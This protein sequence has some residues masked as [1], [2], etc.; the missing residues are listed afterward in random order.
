MEFRRC[1][2]AVLHARRF[3]DPGRP[4]LIFGNSLGTDL[5]IWSA[6][7]PALLDR[8]GI[9]LHDQ[10]G[11]GLSEASSGPH[12]IDG[13]AADL[14]A[15]AD[16]VGAE[17]FGLVG[18]SV[19]GMVA[20]TVAARHPDRVSALVLC[21]TAARIGDAPG[22]EARIRSVNAG[23]VEG[24]AD[25]VME[26][27]FTDG[28]RLANPVALRG[29]RTMLPL[30]P[31]GGYAATCMAIRDADLRR[32]AAGIRAPTLCIAGDQDLSTPPDLVREAADLVP[33]AAFVTIAGAG[34]IPC[35]EQPAAFARLIGS[36][37]DETWAK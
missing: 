8:Y 4:L 33:D 30:Q 7:V 16:V 37:M 31:A 15:L 14:V 2:G 1:N 13:L 11:H 34:H 28:Y 27:W 19:G 32:S 10:R 36:H 3:G 17:R 5:R 22:S 25:G 21:D 20:Q 29:W 24:I 18:L 6:V 23:G 9:L 35:V 12:S 26:R